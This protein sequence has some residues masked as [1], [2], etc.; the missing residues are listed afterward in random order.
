MY[1]ARTLPSFAGRG[2]SDISLDCCRYLCG[3][4]GSGL[5]PRPIGGSGRLCGQRARKERK[6]DG[7]MCT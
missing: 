4:L 1:R 2:C 7:V 6:G 3:E 5:D